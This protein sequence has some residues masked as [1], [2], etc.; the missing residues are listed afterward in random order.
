MT[1]SIWGSGFANTTAGVNATTVTIGGSPCAI[2]A[3]SAF[4]I[5]CTLA[6]TPAGTYPILVN[7]PGVGLAAQATNGA[8]SITTTL[9]VT[10]LSRSEI[11]LGGG[12]TLTLGGTG[13]IAPPYPLLAS[14]TYGAQSV[15]I[16]NSPCS[17]VNVT[18]TSITCTTGPIITK[19]ALAQ[20]NVWKAVT[21]APA[22][23]TMAPAI[24]NGFDGDVATAL[25]T[26]SV[27]IDLG[28]TTLGIVTEV[29]FFPTY[30]AVRNMAGAVFAGSVDGVAWTTL[31]VAS[32][33]PN[34]GW[35][36]IVVI[37]EYASV[38]NFANATGY[39]YL[40][41]NLVTGACSLQE[42]VFTGY[43]IAN[44]PAGGS[45]PVYVAVTGPSEPRAVLASIT[46]ALAT[47]SRRP[48]SR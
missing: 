8:S 40:R 46:P 29:S 23:G 19:E 32:S 9:N 15:T 45:C 21:L 33:S 6:G 48:S 42:V 31:A 17:I 36:S 43:S 13:F 18:A 11:G 34:E 25:L 2:I 5:N 24:T 35:N 28:P 20:R 3:G 26:C 22:V 39:R 7:V 30:R 41:M 27:Q 16:C 38:A 14:S 1:L 12:T 10:S 47:S 4:S 37:D 44:V